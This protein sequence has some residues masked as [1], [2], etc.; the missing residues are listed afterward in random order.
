[1]TAPLFPEP[2][3]AVHD[4]VEAGCGHAAATPARM[5][6]AAAGCRNERDMVGV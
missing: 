6:A 3:H 4:A 5:S 1:V 2:R